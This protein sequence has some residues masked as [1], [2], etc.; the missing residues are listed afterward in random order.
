MSI[1]EAEMMDPQERMFIE[2]VW[3]AVEDAGYNKK[4]LANKK[5]VFLQQQCIATISYSVLRK[6]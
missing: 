2:T 5:S 4:E 1:R 6:H 3:H